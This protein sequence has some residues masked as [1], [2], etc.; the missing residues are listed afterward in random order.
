MLLLFCLTSLP[1]FSSS[2]LNALLNNHVFLFCLKAFEFAVSSAES[3]S[4]PGVHVIPHCLNNFAR[5]LPLWWSPSIHLIKMA[6]CLCTTLPP[7]LLWFIYFVYEDTYHLSI[8][9]LS[10][11]SLMNVNWGQDFFLCCIPCVWNDGSTHSQ[12]SISSSRVK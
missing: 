12:P 9:W 3:R 8:T 6:V 4:A 11:F 7:F 10:I 5:M 1:L 2:H